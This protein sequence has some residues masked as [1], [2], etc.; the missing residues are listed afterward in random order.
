MFT[1]LAWNVERV[2]WQT[3]LGTQWA[4]HLRESQGECI[5]LLTPGPYDN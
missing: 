2:L 3:S 4:S 5:L 1:A